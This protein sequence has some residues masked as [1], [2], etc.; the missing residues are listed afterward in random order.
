MSSARPY[1][2]SGLLL[3]GTDTGVGKTT[4]ARGLLRIAHDRNQRLIPFKP[5]ETGCDGNPP[6]DASYLLEA[7]SLPGLTLDDVCP[8]AFAAPLAP[9]I[10]AGLERRSIDIDSIV[11]RAGRLS[12]LGDALLV[13]TAGGLLTPW[14]RGFTAADL[15]A[16]LALPVL[17]VAANRLGVINHTALVAAE[18]RRRGLPCIGFVLVDVSSTPTPDRPFNATEIASHTGIPSLGT[19]RHIPDLQTSTIARHVAADLDLGTLLGA[20]AD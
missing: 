8:Y 17:I 7:A 3:A 16:V 6:R 11:A 19:L 12:G 15:A 4:V 20:R 5:V 10:A 18:C 2:Q 13:E 1:P 14:A 9:S